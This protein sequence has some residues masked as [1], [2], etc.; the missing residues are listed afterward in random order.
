[1]G[2]DQIQVVDFETESIC[3][4]IGLLDVEL[5]QA[6]YGDADSVLDGDLQSYWESR[7][8]QDLTFK[9]E[10]PQTITEI[11]M[12]VYEG[13]SRVQ[14]FD[15]TS[16]NEARDWKEFLIDVES[17]MSN[18]IESYQVEIKNTDMVKLTF[19]NEVNLISEV[20]FWG[21]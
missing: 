15:V 10:N 19:Y 7:G 8:E 4:E 18:G 14:S 9:F 17:I 20:E 5:V 21:C 2:K 11:G 6:S 13:E 12:A 16:R 3:E 1:M